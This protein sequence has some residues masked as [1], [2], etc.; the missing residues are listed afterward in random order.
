VGASA[1]AASSL[2]AKGNW[3]RLLHLKIKIS[4]FKM[5]LAMP[6]GK[7]LQ[8]DYERVYK[9]MRIYLYTALSIK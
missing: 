1:D 4:K 9:Y 5:D 8:Q 7:A 2:Q 3:G 6:D